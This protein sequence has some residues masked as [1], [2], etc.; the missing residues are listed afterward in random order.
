MVQELGVCG[1]TKEP[2]VQGSLCSSHFDC[3]GMFCSLE[4]LGFGC[5]AYGSPEE[6]R[7]C[8]PCVDIQATHP[9]EPDIHTLICRASISVSGSCDVCPGQGQPAAAPLRG[10]VGIVDGRDDKYHIYG[11]MEAGFSWVRLQQSFG[12]G[13]LES[14]PGGALL[15]A[16]GIAAGIDTRTAGDMIKYLCETDASLLDGCGGHGNPYHYHEDMSCLYRSNETTGHSSRIGTALDGNGIYG[17]YIGF[18]G[19]LPTDL[20]ACGGRYG[21][22]PGVCSSSRSC[23]Y[24]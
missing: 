11:P 6:G 15:A 16:Q 21:I 17:K 19:Q 8:Q 5:P 18:G 24:V 23:S 3:P 9:F 14:A 22:T 7:F 13:E 2:Y 12:C 20:D 10:P 1:A 4:C